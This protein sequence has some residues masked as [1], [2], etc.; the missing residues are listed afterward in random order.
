[1]GARAICRIRSYS[2][3]AEPPFPW[4]NRET[5]VSFAT[6]P[7]KSRRR[8]QRRKPVPASPRRRNFQS[9][10]HPYAQSIEN[11]YRVSP[12]LPR[13][14]FPP[15]RLTR[16]PIFRQGVRTVWEIADIPDYNGPLLR[17]PIHT[18]TGL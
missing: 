3:A 7:E 1:M 4:R 9:P 8:R 16:S 6:L 17:F 18:S 13:Q 14:S 12:P 11:L 15:C 2:P 10:V 5:L